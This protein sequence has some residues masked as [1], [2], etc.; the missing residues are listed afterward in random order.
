MPDELNAT[1]YMM[2]AERESRVPS[3]FVFRRNA[4]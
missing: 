1:R 3:W 4:D 2:K